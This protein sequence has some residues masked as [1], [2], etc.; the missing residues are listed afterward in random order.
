MRNIIKSHDFVVSIIVFVCTI[1]IGWGISMILPSTLHNGIS[2][3]I[4]TLTMIIPLIIWDLLLIKNKREIFLR[5]ARRSRMIFIIGI[6]FIVIGFVMVITQLNFESEIQPT[7][8]T[9][10]I[11]TTTTISE[12]NLPTFLDGKQ[13]LTLRLG[14]MSMIG[15]VA[16]L[17]NEPHYFKIGEYKLINFYINNHTL[18]AD[19]V[20]YGGD[21]SPF[22]ELKQNVLLSEPQG[23]DLNY[24]NSAIEIVDERQNPVFQLIYKSPYDIVINGFLYYPNGF[25]FVNEDGRMIMNP[26]TPVDYSLIR[27]FKYPSLQYQ[28]QRIVP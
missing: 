13:E 9:N 15:T 21:N 17:I 24:D 27:I 20:L 4:L 3:I 19:T 26:K 8:T 7:N 23:W 14:M 28:G 25:I 11:T 1:G 12:I 22:V 10:S 18:Y 2:I 6:A 16:E 5:K